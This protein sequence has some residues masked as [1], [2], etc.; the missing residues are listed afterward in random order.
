MKLSLLCRCPLLAM[1]VW[2]M[3]SQINAID[4]F[5]ADFI[6][7][8]MPVISAAVIRRAIGSP[9]KLRTGFQ[10]LEEFCSYCSNQLKI[11]VATV[12]DFV[13]N[14][15]NAEHYILDFTTS[16]IMHSHDVIFK[17]C[18]PLTHA[19][20]LAWTEFA[21]KLCNAIQA[22][23]CGLK[24]AMLT[25]HLP[26]VKCVHTTCRWPL[27]GWEIPE[28]SRIYS[29]RTLKVC[30]TSF[31]PSCKCHQWSLEHQVQ[32]SL[33]VPALLHAEGTRLNTQLWEFNA[34]PRLTRG[35]WKEYL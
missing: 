16:S 35:L 27:R 18:F 1:D 30:D 5:H 31:R 4:L 8:F 2:L 15:A 17:P 10:V 32:E 21:K 3:I 14:G 9:W 25:K 19:L 13:P 11:T 6:V 7:W 33:R 29:Q 26:C 12:T 28:S 23:L 24:A 22:A 34:S 20:S